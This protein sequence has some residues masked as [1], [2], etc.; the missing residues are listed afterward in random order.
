MCAGRDPVIGRD[1]PLAPDTQVG[2]GRT[3]TVWGS[4]HDR[5]YAEETR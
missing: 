5:P 1:T 2:S 4:G 3:F